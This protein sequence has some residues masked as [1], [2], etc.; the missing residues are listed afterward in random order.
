MGKTFLKYGGEF[1]ISDTLSTPAGE[2]QCLASTG[3]FLVENWKKFGT[4]L[5]ANNVWT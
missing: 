1:A 4:I 3:K 2:R 5:G